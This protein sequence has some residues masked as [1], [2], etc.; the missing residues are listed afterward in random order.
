MPLV[1]PVKPSGLNSEGQ[2]FLN[3]NAPEH[4]DSQSNLSLPLRSTTIRTNRK[5][6][7][8]AIL[9]HEN[10]KILTKEEFCQHLHEA[11]HALGHLT[12]SLVCGIHIA[13]ADR[14]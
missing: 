6:F 9:P 7:R 8:F 12:R 11:V 3:S 1:I 14:G 13:N 4:E 5:E 2:V 10:N